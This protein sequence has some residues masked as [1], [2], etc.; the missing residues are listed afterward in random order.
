MNQLHLVQAVFVSFHN[1]DKI[2]LYSVYP[3]TYFLF[4][5]FYQWI[6]NVVVFYI[7]QCYFAIRFVLDLNI[8][9][10]FW[11]FIHFFSLSLCILLCRKKTILFSFFCWLWLFTSAYFNWK[12]CFITPR[13]RYF[14]Q[15]M[16]YLHSLIRYLLNDMDFF[17]RYN[18][19]P[20]YSLIRQNSILSRYSQLNFSL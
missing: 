12:I 17:F 20:I 7:E 10:F 5:S 18:K 1:L 3:F 6:E 2:V 14:M 13:K 4:F 15:S 11:V 9:F 16:F 8:L 19:L